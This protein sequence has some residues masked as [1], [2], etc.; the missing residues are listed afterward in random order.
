MNRGI[1]KIDNMS[2]R[3]KDRS[4][5]SSGGPENKRKVRESQ[6][7]GNELIGE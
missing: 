4:E 7:S 6:V 1:R 5:S 3:E 2:E